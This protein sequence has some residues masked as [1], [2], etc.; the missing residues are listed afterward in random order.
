[1]KEIWWN[2]VMENDSTFDG[3]FFYAVES[4]GIYCK[5]SCPS[6][7]PKRENVRFFATKEEAEA[8]GFRPCKR[9]RPDLL[10]YDPA[11]EIAK[12]IAASI[13][14][15]FHDES[16]AGFTFPLGI[17]KKHGSEVFKKVYGKTMAQYTKEVRIQK[18]CELLQEGMSIVETASAVGYENLSGFYTQFKKVKAMT[19]SKY[20]ERYSKHMSRG[21]VETPIG[22]LNIVCSKEAVLHVK[23]AEKEEEPFEALISNGSDG[24]YL[25]CKEELE[26]YFAGKRTTFDLPLAPE[27]TDFQKKVWQ[28]L[29]DIPYGETRNYKELATM[30]GNPKASRAVG[31][32]NHEN[33]IMI[34]IPCHRVIGKDGTLVGYAGGLSVKEYLLDLE[35]KHYK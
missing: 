32:A 2:A 23:M 13:H 16:F 8:A 1:M 22:K 18:A 19:P 9:C 12:D 30:A 15:R 34:I 25:S 6:K 26:E 24:I 17:S 14:Q 31:M 33:P 3:K 27:G 10:E 11:L 29:C 35:K 21:V 4:T 20:R 28:K 5:P 7:A